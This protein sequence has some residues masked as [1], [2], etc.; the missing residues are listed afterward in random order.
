MGIENQ[1][2]SPQEVHNQH[3]L[4]AITKKFNQKFD[5]EKDPDPEE[6]LGTIFSHPLSKQVYLTMQ[7]RIEESIYFMA[8]DGRIRE[9]E[10]KRDDTTDRN[11]TESFGGEPIADALMEIPIEENILYLI[12]R[13]ELYE[14]REGTLPQF[15]SPQDKIKLEEEV[16]EKPEA[17]IIEVYEFNKEKLYRYIKE[18]A[19]DDY[20]IDLLSRSANAG[21]F[22]YWLSEY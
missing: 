17:E 6:F 2:T 16:P 14:G 13:V 21:K 8:A 20:V 7:S 4:E 3:Y 5:L 22:K 19:D 10:V 9:L 1:F 18:H 15:I 12:K 11:N